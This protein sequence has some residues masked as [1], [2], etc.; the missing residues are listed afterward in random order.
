MCRVYGNPPKYV[1]ACA[2]TTY[3]NWRVPFKFL[4]HDWNADR[5]HLTRAV[6][7]MF[8]IEPKKKPIER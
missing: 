1:R 4:G 3:P 6:V 7:R 5:G 2:R 8:G